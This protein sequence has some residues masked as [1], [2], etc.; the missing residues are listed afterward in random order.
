MSKKKW[1]LAIWGILIIFMFGAFISGCNSQPAATFGYIETGFGPNEHDMEKYALLFPHH[2][3]SFMKNAE[4]DDY[5]SKYGGSIHDDH[6]EKYPYMRTLFAGMPFSLEYNEDRGHVYSMTDLVEIKRVTSL[7][8]GRQQMG[9][10]LTCKTVEAFDLQVEMGLDYYSTPLNEL[11]PDI[12][13]GFS[14]SV[15]H[16]PQSMKLR[17]AQQPFIDAMARIGED[18]TKA[19]QQELRTYVCAQCH[20]E[21]YFNPARQGEVTF[22]WDKGFTPGDMEQY[23]NEIAGPLYGF[24]QDWIHPMTGTPLLKAQHPE[25]EMYQGSIHQING[26][27]CADCHMPYVKQGNQ[28]I[29]SHWMT[30]PL[31][32]MEQSCT[33]CHRQNVE[34]LRDYVYSKQDKTFEMLK[35][36]G[37]YNEQAINTIAK[38]IELGASDEALKEAR[39]LHRQAQWRWDYVAAENSMGFH[40]NPLALSTLSESIEL[41]HQATMAAA[42]A[43]NFHD[44]PELK[45][46]GDYVY[47]RLEQS[48]WSRDK[49]RSYAPSHMTWH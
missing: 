10:C 21:Y 27:S 23:Y 4:M 28:K 48:G 5:H 18:V 20:V 26:I 38:A 8:G 9:S 12:K 14:C 15:C 37:S 2:Y 43:G 35:K 13:H 11:I 45:P 44:I 31:K 46:Y 25:F 29:S 7:P 49:G 32:H 1:L 22:P 39:D 40:N 34:E 33:V 24:N 47:E 36:A 19:T 16:D 6:L 17:V 30:S 41:A 42:R 3:D